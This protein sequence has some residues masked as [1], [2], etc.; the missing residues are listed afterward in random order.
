[1][2]WL[3]G[4]H[5]A[6]VQTRAVHVPAVQVPPAVNTPA[7][8]TP[9]V[10]VPPPDVQALFVVYHD[11]EQMPPLEAL[12]Q[13]LGDVNFDTEQAPALVQVLYVE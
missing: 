2:L 6:W 13:E 8:Y 9:F 5:V 11:F 1:V 3:L 7:V 10:H 12:V 4:F